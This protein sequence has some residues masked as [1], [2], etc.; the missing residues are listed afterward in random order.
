MFWR[1]YHLQALLPHFE[2]RKLNSILGYD[3]GTINIFLVN[4][5]VETLL[6][7]NKFVAAVI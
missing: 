6:F 3:I 4:V 1:E 7:K 2:L 5:Q